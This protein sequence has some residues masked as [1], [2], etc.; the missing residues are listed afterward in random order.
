VISA[1]YALA[2]HSVEIRSEYPEV[3][4]LW[5]DYAC[6]SEPEF[7]VEVTPEDLEKE[8]ERALRSA[9]REG[10]TEVYSSDASLEALAVYRKFAEKMTEYGVV[11]FH[12]SA[13]CLDGQA[14]LFTAPSGTGKSTHAA[15]WRRAF[16]ERAF[17]INDD[18][19]MIKID[20]DGATVFGTPY[21]GKHRLGTN[22]SAPLRAICLL[23][24]GEKNEI[25]EI[26]APE[27][28]RTVVQQTFRPDSG[29]ALAATLTLVDSLM[30]N[31]R[32][33]NLRCNMDIEAALVAYEGMKGDKQ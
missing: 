15:L 18:K 29:K 31:V 33:Y 32:F 13:I 21:N 26:G 9:L 10:R 30:K 16:G 19:P 27:A 20:G 3:H 12:G 24:R 1:V 4:S 11:L 28:Y 23:E 2:G 8:R 5:R 14:Y 25:R 17:M 22:A 7:L 6:G